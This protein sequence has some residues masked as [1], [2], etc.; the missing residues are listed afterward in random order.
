MYLRLYKALVLSVMEYGSPVTEGAIGESCKEFGKV[1]RSAMIK[2]SGC[3]NSRNT[4]TLEFLT[5]TEPID[6]PGSS[7]D[8]CKA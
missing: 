1:H 3:L 2:A 8:S 7:E 5:K 6:S 4:E